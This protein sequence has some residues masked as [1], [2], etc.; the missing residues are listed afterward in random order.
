[1]IDMKEAGNVCFH[2]ETILMT[3]H[4]LKLFLMHCRK[5]M[6]L[7]VMGILDTKQRDKNILKSY[8]TAP[9]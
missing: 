3:R 1:M 9:L 6:T 4:G 2:K 8:L 7:D 5:P